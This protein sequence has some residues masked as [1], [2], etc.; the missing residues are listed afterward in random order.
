MSQ[1]PVPD[2]HSVPGPARDPAVMRDHKDCHAFPVQFF[3]EIHDL[4]SRLGIQR[5][6]RLIRK[7]DHRVVDQRSCDRD[8]L[9]LAAGQ[10]IRVEIQPVGETDPGQCLFCE[11]P[12]LLSGHIGVSQGKFYVFERRLSRKQLKILEDKTPIRFMSVDFP[13]PEGPM[14]AVK[15]PSSTV[16]LMFLSAGT[17]IFPW[18]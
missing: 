8:S 7:D 4:C 14:I 12:S 16:K 15:S 3:K 17:S 5:S 1:L 9:L 2:L 13:D 10:L 18:K 11:L 6:R